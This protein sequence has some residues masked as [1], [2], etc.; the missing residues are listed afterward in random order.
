MGYTR[1]HLHV[2]VDGHK[3]RTSSMYK[4]Y[5]NKHGNVPV[6]VLKRFDVLKKCKNN[7]DSSVHEMVFIRELKPTLNVQSD[8][9][10]AK[11]FL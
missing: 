1:G 6:D 7:F 8:S 3:Q 10:R 11:V 2:R 4:H 5:H 9:I